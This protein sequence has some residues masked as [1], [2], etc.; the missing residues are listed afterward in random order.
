MKKPRKAEEKGSFQDP[1]H[2]KYPFSKHSHII[3][4]KSRLIQGVSV[5]WNAV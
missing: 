5:H 1:T 2:V 3:N 4:I